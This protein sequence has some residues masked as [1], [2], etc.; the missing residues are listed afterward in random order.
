M[1]FL[2]KK[3]PWLIL[4]ITFLLSGCGFH[5][6]DKTEVPKQFK[7][8]SL[9]SLEPYSA[10]VRDVKYALKI[11][12]VNLVDATDDVSVP[13]LRLMQYEISRNTVSVYQDGKAAEYQLILDVDAQVVIAGKDIYPI[14]V[15]IFRSFFDNPAAALAKD[16]EQNLIKNEMY[17]QAAE[18]LIRK[19]KAVNVT[20]QKSTQ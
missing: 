7:T 8:M 19:L 11:N 20:D 5:L 6:Q 1:S 16:T 13:S 12:G 14:K 10:L 9:Y 15:K 17:S 3:C 2:I 4:L 18:Q